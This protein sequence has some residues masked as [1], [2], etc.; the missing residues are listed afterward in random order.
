M[1]DTRQT[2]ATI[3]ELARTL[4]ERRGSTSSATIKMSAAGVVMPEV[5][6]AAGTEEAD[7]ST[8]VDQAIRSFRD[9]LDKATHDGGT[10]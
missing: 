2:R 10:K 3:S 1:S 7:V 6:I 9:M 8:M 4:A 5:T